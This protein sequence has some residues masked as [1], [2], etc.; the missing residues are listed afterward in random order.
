MANFVLRFSRCRFRTFKDLNPVE[1]VRCENQ[2]VA[3]LSLS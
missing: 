2:M 3:D 1:A